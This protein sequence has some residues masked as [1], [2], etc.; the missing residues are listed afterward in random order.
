MPADR[1]VPFTRR[2]A[3]LFSEPLETW[4]K[5]CRDRDEFNALLKA[6]DGI[7]HA[8]IEWVEER[9]Q[10]IEKGKGVRTTP[11]RLRLAILRDGIIGLTEAKFLC[12]AVEAA[13]RR[14][15]VDWA[16]SQKVTIKQMVSFLKYMDKKDKDN[17]S[18]R[19]SLPAFVSQ[20]LFS[21]T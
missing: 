7:A 16:D 13:L 21:Q 15:L 5:S 17:L 6:T 8:W 12:D 14:M 20:L 19:E 9:A 3:D 10:L 18:K 1:S 4:L 2:R 11:I